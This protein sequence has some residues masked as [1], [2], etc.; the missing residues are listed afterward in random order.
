MNQEY[1]SVVVEI[2]HPS[3]TKI[4]DGESTPR[5]EIEYEAA[6]LKKFDKAVRKAMVTIG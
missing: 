1:C 3:K 4:V 2:N 5:T 6:W